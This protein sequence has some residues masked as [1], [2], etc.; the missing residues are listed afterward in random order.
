MKD[1][2]PFFSLRAWAPLLAAAG[3]AGCTTMADLPPGSPF[4]QVQGRYGAPTVTCP[5]PDGSRRVVWSQQPFGQ[6]AWGGMVDPA[7][8]MGRIDPVLTDEHFRVLD[9]GTWTPEQVTCEFGPPAEVSQAG[10][11]SVRQVIW[12]YRYKQ[13]GVWNSLMYVYLGRNGDRVTRFHP[14]PDPMYEDRDSWLGW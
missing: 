8:R 12:A 6:Y 9:Q 11:P 14:G 7:G 3:L 2:S 13:D 4:E 5:L 1:T 10:L